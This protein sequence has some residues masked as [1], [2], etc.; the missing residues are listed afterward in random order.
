MKVVVTSGPVMVRRARLAMAG[1]EWLSMMLRDFRAAAVSE[2]PVGGICL[3]ALVGQLGFKAFPGRSGAFVSWGVT[4]P[5]RLRI[6][7]IVEMAGTL[8]MLGSG[9]NKVGGDGVG[10]GV[11]ASSGQGLAQH[12]DAVFDIDGGGLRAVVRAS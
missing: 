7:Q 1:R 12:D 6:R 10:A 2:V 8:G 3:P 11:E 4:K 5:R 9:G